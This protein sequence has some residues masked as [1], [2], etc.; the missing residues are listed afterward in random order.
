MFKMTILEIAMTCWSIETYVTL[1]RPVG[2]DRPGLA[3]IKNLFIVE[4][5][6]F[7]PELSH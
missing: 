2:L 4:T 5:P 3:S 6:G 7:E 1:A